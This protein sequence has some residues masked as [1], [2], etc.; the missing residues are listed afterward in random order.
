MDEIKNNITFNDEMSE[1][2]DRFLRKEM[3]EAEAKAF[4]EEVKT[5]PELKECY[6]RQFNLMRAIKFEK[7][8]EIMKEKEA[9]LSKVE[10]DTSSD[11]RAPFF[12]R[13]KY[14]LSTVAVAAAMVCGVFVWDG[15]V[16]KDVGDR[17]Y[18][19]VIRGGEDSIDQLVKEEKY[20]EALD[21]IDKELAVGT[22]FV[23]SAAAAAHEQEM[24]A[25]KYRKALIYLKMGKKH[26]AKKILKK[27]KDPQSQKVLDE[28]LW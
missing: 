28:L 19:Q 21:A 14:V 15:S 25:L 3:S 11:V 27:L 8:S 5:N 10:T 9:E 26:E 23:D 7:M 18:S 22:E 1:R 20:S 12:V 17:M 13:Y 2:V 6:Q 4:V 24:N 16:T